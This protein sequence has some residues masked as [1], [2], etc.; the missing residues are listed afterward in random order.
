MS[1]VV[2]YC[3]TG[4][5]NVCLYDTHIDKI[6]FARM[7]KSAKFVGEFRGLM[8]AIKY[9]QMTYKDRDIVLVTDG[10]TES[11]VLNGNSNNHRN[12]TKDYSML[13]VLQ[14]EKARLNNIINVLWL[15]R[16]KNH[17]GIFLQKLCSKRIKSRQ[18]N[19]KKIFNIHQ[20]DEVSFVD[21]Q[22]K[23]GVD[24]PQFLMKDY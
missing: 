7:G 19:G 17:A 16:G 22:I 14:L 11:D 23:I 21:N 8:F 13:V 3:D 6:L 10:K 4:G 15:P 2:I 20:F 18:L 12:P 24:V 9:I 5:R 1:R